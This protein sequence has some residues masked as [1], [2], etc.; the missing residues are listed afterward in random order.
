LSIL[1]YRLTDNFFNNCDL[2]IDVV[3]LLSQ[4]SASAVEFI[5]HL[6]GSFV[7]LPSDFSK[8]LIY[9]LLGRLAGESFDCDVSN[10]GFNACD[11]FIQSSH[12]VSLTF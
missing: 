7:F 6:F 10:L 2:V 3:E 11:F 8:V 1:F 9:F 5:P 4:F 12:F